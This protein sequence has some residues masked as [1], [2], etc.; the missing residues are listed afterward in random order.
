MTL[1]HVTENEALYTLVCLCIF[2]GMMNDAKLPSKA[3]AFA[4]ECFLQPGVLS[5]MSSLLTH[6]QGSISNLE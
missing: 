2:S 1:S 6:W 5:G 3:G 4:G